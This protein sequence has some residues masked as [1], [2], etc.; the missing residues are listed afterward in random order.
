M[1]MNSRASPHSDTTT[2]ASAS[3][4]QRPHE[5]R[6]TSGKTRGA[7]C[8]RRWTPD[9]QD[10]PLMTTEL[11]Q[12][13]KRRMLRRSRSEKH[14]CTMTPPVKPSILVI[15][16][17]TRWMSHPAL[18]ELQPGPRLSTTLLTA[19]R[20]DAR[21][22]V[23]QGPDDQVEGVDILRHAGVRL[24]SS[25]HHLRAGGL[26]ELDSG[27]RRADTEKVRNLLASCSFLLHEHRNR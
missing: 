15:D 9:M 6:K 23:L 1:I 2:V 27:Q 24:E 16:P 8:A 13:R 25:L 7:L 12:A 26:D 22:S 21:L 17:A 3:W 4:Q 18:N 19:L 10:E 20:F 5:T 14:N 11:M